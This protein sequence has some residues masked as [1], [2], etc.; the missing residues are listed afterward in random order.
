M[1]KIIITIFVLLITSTL[2]SQEW[3]YHPVEGS[4][5]FVRDFISYTDSSFILVKDYYTVVEYIPGSDSYKE[6]FTVK[7]SQKHYTLGEDNSLWFMSRGNISSF[8]LNTGERIEYDSLIREEDRERLWKGVNAWALTPDPGSR[9]TLTNARHLYFLTPDTAEYHY[10]P[11]YLGLDSTLFWGDRLLFKDNQAVFLD[12]VYKKQ[13]VF[14]DLENP[15]DNIIQKLPD[16]IKDE[17]LT[18]AEIEFI[19]DDILCQFYK[20]SG[21]AGIPDYSYIC[22]ANETEFRKIEIPY[23][24]S[25]EAE[26]CWICDFEAVN[27][28]LIALSLKIGKGEEV[29][30]ENRIIFID[31]TGK[32]RYE[33]ILPKLLPD[34][35]N[36]NN[37]GKEVQFTQARELRV[38]GNSLYMVASGGDHLGVLEFKLPDISGIEAETERLHIPTIDIDKIYPN[39][40]SSNVSLVFR[41][42]QEDAQKLKVEL[43]DY[44]GRRYE[45]GSYEVTEYNPAIYE[46]TINI[47]ISGIPAG[48]KYIMLKNSEESEIIGI[49][50]K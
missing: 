14:M 39:P 2:H 8:N 34:G 20:L 16:F 44:L 22:I 17:G 9:A 5:S 37:T 27:S 42:K 46:G 23:I 41:C 7:S 11:D 15:S 48:P 33:A 10:V 49:M 21:L 26:Y 6:L 40:V 24:D 3:V 13:L 45:I 19:G 43:Y 31:R 32:V 36:S 29:E 28:N 50:V 4:S 18:P 47:N 38:M 12:M 25:V 1:K 35:P 30:E